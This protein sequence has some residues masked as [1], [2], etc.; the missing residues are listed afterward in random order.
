MKRALIIDVDGSGNCK[1]VV[2]SKF[3]DKTTITWCSGVGY[4]YIV[5]CQFLAA[6]AGQSD[7]NHLFFSF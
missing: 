2:R 5:H 6:S 3:F 1:R 7:F 4:D